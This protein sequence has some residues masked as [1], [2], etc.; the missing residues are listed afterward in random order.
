M[1]AKI[2]LQRLLPGI[3][4]LLVTALILFSCRP[5]KKPPASDSGPAESLKK[6][7]VLVDYRD[8]KKVDV[9]IDGDVFTSYIYPEVL[10]KPVLFPVRSARGTVITRGF[11]LK[12]REGER[13]DHPHQVGVWF[14]F[15][16]VN[17]INFWKGINARILHRGV[18]RAES[19]EALGVLEIAADWQIQS[20]D[21]TWHT[22]LQEKTIFEFSGDENTRT[23]ERITQLTAQ[24]EEVVF[25]D[26]KD[27]L[28]GIR[29]ARELELPSDEA[30]ILIGADGKPGEDPVMDTKGVSGRYL[31]SEGI[32]GYEVWGKRADWVS[33]SSRIADEEIAVTV[34]DHPGNFGFPSYWHARDYGLLAVNNLGARAFDENAEPVSL[35]LQPG[36]STTFR[37][38][39]YIT[40]GGQANAR[41]LDA[42]SEEFRNR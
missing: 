21:G 18:K 3:I 2:V 39:I 4:L 27:G 31:N 17:G 28:L 35:R 12:P 14:A 41:S 1:K 25:T 29:L 33:L 40:S 30:H 34:F 26:I 42:V 6:G 5:G 8:Q 15:E 37:H 22:L 32:E 16:D 9:F 19:R 20:D 24:E 13:I 38:R 10:A 36:E 7:V 23:I 11:P